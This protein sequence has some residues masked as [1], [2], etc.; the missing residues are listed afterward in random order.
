MTTLEIDTITDSV[1][2]LMTEAFA[3]PPD[4]RETWFI[5]NRPD[6][7]ILGAIA[8]VTAAEASTPVGGSSESGAT[9]AGNVEHLR[10]YLANAN[11]ALSGGEYSPDWT[12]SWL[13]SSVDEAAW[14]D[15]RRSLRAEFETFCR[16]I[17]QQ[18]ELP[19]PFLNGVLAMIPHAAFHLGII[20][21][22][23]ERVW[24]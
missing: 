16:L 19:G 8:D 23:I 17:K 11:N 24:E 20:R 10:W 22:L 1:V 5:D 2:T 3:G 18:E 15:L 6:S 13:V 14:E 4:P 12:K 9:I 21:Q 7:G